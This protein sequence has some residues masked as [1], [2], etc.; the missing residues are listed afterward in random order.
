MTG[1]KAMIDAYFICWRIYRI[2][3]N[4]LSGRP[5][6]E[7]NWERVLERLPTPQDNVTIWVGSIPAQYF[8]VKKQVDASLKY[9]FGGWR[10]V[11]ASRDDAID[12]AVSQAEEQ[13]PE[14]AMWM[15]LQLRRD[16]VP[17]TD[18][19]DDHYLWNDVDE[20]TRLAESFRKAAARVFDTVAAAMLIEMPSW[21]RQTLDDRD[22][23][24]VG[25]AGKGMTF[26][27]LFTVGQAIVSIT[28]DWAQLPSA[29]LDRVADKVQVLLSDDW[30]RI[31]QS[32]KWMTAGTRDPG[33]SLRRFM[34][35]YFG[36]EVLAGRFQ[37]VEGKNTV[38]NIEAAAGLPLKELVWPK[39]SDDSSEPWRSLTFQFAIMAVAMSPET[40]GEDIQGFKKLQKVRNQ[41]A[42]GGSADMSTLPYE[43][44]EEL[45]RRYLK[46]AVLTS[47]VG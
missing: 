45:L 1:S 46:F 32:A 18:Q 38:A 28:H 24:Y 9:L 6:G 2:P 7:R 12:E 43:E 34:F 14:G 10:E 17:L 5:E 11:A 40:A 16:N 13:T 3:D 30:L 42:H 19:R 39:P 4:Y 20:S 23:V 25:A 33:D 8:D 37:H 27:P 41:L 36:L 22:R 29:D 15:T 26:I 44:A 31:A 21:V 47:A 35:A